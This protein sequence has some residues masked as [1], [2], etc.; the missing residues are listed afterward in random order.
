VEPDRVQQWASAGQSLWVVRI[1]GTLY[2]VSASAF[3][4]MIPCSIALNES[5]VEFEWPEVFRA[6]IPMMVDRDKV[7]V[8]LEHL[9]V[10]LDYWYAKNGTVTA[11]D[12]RY[13]LYVHSAKD[14]LIKS[15]EPESAFT[16]EY[17]ERLAKDALAMPKISMRPFEIDLML[18][19]PMK[20]QR[21][22]ECPAP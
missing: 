2:V 5:Q 21:K 18:S 10:L 7:Y 20:S 6:G 11:V 13:I 12:C 15:S 16:P 17:T 3:K 8:S 14:A 19:T 9:S 4:D 22:G 1:N